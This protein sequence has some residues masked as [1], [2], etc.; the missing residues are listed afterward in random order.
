MSILLH[1]AKRIAELDCLTVEV[2]RS[3]TI[4][5]TRTPGEEYSVRSQTGRTCA[6]FSAVSEY[7]FD[8]RT[9]TVKAYLLTFVFK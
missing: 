9:L 5:H 1:A 4:R 6:V 2:S 3:H 8:F 7:L